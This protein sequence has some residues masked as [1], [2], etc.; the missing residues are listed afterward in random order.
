MNDSIIYQKLVRDRIP[1][2]IS[3][4]GKTPQTRILEQSEFKDAVGAKLLEETYELYSEWKKGD[5]GAILKE[6]AD[7]LEILL[8]ALREHGLT[9]DDLMAMRH[10]RALE[11]GDF[12]EKIFLE[13]VGECNF[14][15]PDIQS[16]PTLI[17]NPIQQ[18]RLIQIIRGE[19]AQSK[20]A[21]IASAF[22]SPGITNLLMADMENFLQQ[23]GSLRILL[24]TMGN[25]VRPEYFAHLK[26]FLPDSNLRIFHPPD[27]PF[28]QN[29]PAFHVKTFLFLHASGSGSILIG[30]SN[31]TEAGFTRNIEWNYFSSGEVNLPFEGLSPFESAV[32][33]FDHFWNTSAVEVTQNFL[34]GYRKRFQISEMDRRHISPGSA[35]LFEK[36]KGYGDRSVKLVSPNEA[37]KAALDNL[38][39][40]RG[41]GITKAAV[42]AATGVGKTFLA[43]FDFRQSG[44]R[45][46]LFIAHRENILFN[47]RESFVRIMPNHD[48]GSIMGGGNGFTETEG[49]VFAMIQTLSRENH[50]EKFSPEHFDF[51]VIDE[52]HHS[53]ASSYQKILNYFKPA[54]LLGLTATPER[55]DG[56]DVLALCDYNIACEIRLMEAVDKGWL[57]PFQ[58]YAVYDQIDYDQITWRGSRYDEAELDRALEN[59]TRTEIIARNLLKYLPASGKIKAL[60]FCSSIAHACYTARILKDQHGIESIALTGQTPGDERRQAISK[61]QN[62]YD[63][64]K[65]ICCVD[66]FN[67]GIDIPE[68]T[69]VLFLRPTQSFTVFLQQLGR[70]LRLWPGKDFVVALDFVGNFRK[71]H[72][73][74]LAL[75]GFTSIEQ[76]VEFRKTAVGSS[77]WDRL[78]NPCFLSA[79]TDVRRIW[80]DEIRR[81]L[82]GELSAEDRLKMLYLEIREDLEDTSPS[83]MDFLANPRDVDPYI[84][85]RQF[86]SWLK[87]KLY[88]DGTLPDDEMQLLNTMGETFLSYVETDLNPVRSY[89]MVVLLTL[90]NLP[91]TEWMIEDIAG[92]FLSYFLNHPDRIADYDELAKSKN[93]EQFSIRKVVSKLKTMPLHFLSNTPDD[94]F[95]LDKKAGI[96]SLKAGLNSHWNNDGFRRLVKDRV[97]FAV[98]RYFRNSNRKKSPADQGQGDSVV[99]ASGP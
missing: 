13:H 75:T 31:F 53:E 61:L 85:I 94:F 6:S 92:G 67:E 72:V 50:L 10:K 25:I 64:L 15:T 16:C 69:H 12:S 18:K 68:L 4:H 42:I 5:S 87:A 82:R 1:E 86:G 39:R 3:S 47:A 14:F 22:Y 8:T 58:Y 63:E 27:I 83:L 35:G 90:L 80:D 26:S 45:R 89:K 7:V 91:G 66:I 52:F 84:F 65:V 37:Q 99:K 88:C 36:Q 29:P 9:L 38:A 51:I 41:H 28:D 57:S 74:P 46:I 19:F 30:S 97:M 81:V 40:M 77:L 95:V 48:F 76:F 62:D 24:S 43:A 79:D 32:E 98:E 56:R 60:A 54:F 55:M 23:N 59:D 21:W 71:A 33:E 78:P 17:F 73:A 11:R 34:D 49:S 20:T 96:F 70:A 44:C 93:P 2:I